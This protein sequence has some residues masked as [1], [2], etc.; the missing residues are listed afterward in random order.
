MSLNQVTHHD[1]TPRESH[2][3]KATILHHIVSNDMVLAGVA[4]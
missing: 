1:F 3:L 4:S 2:S